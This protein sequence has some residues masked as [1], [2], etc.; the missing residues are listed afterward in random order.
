[1]G[2][3][4]LLDMSVSHKNYDRYYLMTTAHMILLTVSSEAENAFTQLLI[5]RTSTP[6]N[7]QP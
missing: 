3:G 4:E 1:M 2:L 6:K 5:A 7:P